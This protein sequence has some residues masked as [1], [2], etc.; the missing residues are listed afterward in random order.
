MARYRTSPTPNPNSLK[1]TRSDGSLFNVD[2]MLAANDPAE[3]DTELGRALFSIDG[4][5]SVLVMPPFA[6]ISVARGT[7]W[8]AVLP[9]VEAALDAHA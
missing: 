7:D 8:N 4:V 5:T 6:T 2:G 9:A 1:L 3:A